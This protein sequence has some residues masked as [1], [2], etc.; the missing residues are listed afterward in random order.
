M[1]EMVRRSV[2]QSG[3]TGACLAIGI[4][5]LDQSVGRERLVAD[6]GK[7]R[8][9]LIPLGRK[10][11]RQPLGV[12]VRSVGLVGCLCFLGALLCRRIGGL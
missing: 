10:L 9:P 11:R 7:A 5:S 2:R 8:R 4:E 6:F 1:R 12:G 3:Q